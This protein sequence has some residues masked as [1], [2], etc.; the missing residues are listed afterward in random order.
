[1]ATIGKE[2]TVAALAQVASCPIT[3]CLLIEMVILVL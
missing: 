2:R 3:D 1:M